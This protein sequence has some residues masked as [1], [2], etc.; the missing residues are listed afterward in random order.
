MGRA[1]RQKKDYGNAIDEYSAAVNCLSAQDPAKGIL[2]KEM[3]EMYMEAGDI[4]SSISEF[5]KAIQTGQY[6]QYTHLSLG[7]L[8]CRKKRYDLAD[9]EFDKAVD[10][11]PSSHVFFQ[12]IRIHKKYRRIHKCIAAS[13]NYVDKK[14]E[15]DAAENKAILDAIKSHA[16]AGSAGKELS[17]KIL[18]MPL[19]ER[20]AKDKHSYI[21]LP[22][23]GIGQLVAYLRGNDIKI[24]Q[25]DLYV[26][27]GH[28]NMFGKDED[29]IDMEIF[30]DEK[31][32]VE[33]SNG[34]EDEY[35]ENIMRKLEAKTNLKYDVMLLSL[36]CGCPN[37]SGVM[38]VLA[39]AKYIKKKYNAAILVGGH[40]EQ[41]DVLMSH[42]LRNID[43][44]G[45]G[46]G[47]KMLFVALTALK[48]GVN[49]NEVPDKWLVVKGKEMINGNVPYG[50]KADY[51]GLPFH[52]YEYAN[53]KR[54]TPDDKEFECILDG[55]NNSRLKVAEFEL[56]DGCFY[57][58]I[59]CCLSNVKEVFILSPKEA[60]DQLCELKEKY[61]ISN[62]MFM[63]SMINLSKKYVND[64]CDEI[65]SRKLDILWSDCARA[66]NLDRDTLNKMSRAGCV[67][68][69]YGMESASPRLLR[70]MNKGL[71]MGRIEDV[72]RWTH[73]AGILVG[74]ELICGFPGETKEDLDMTIDFVKRNKEHLD[75]CYCNVLYVR[76]TMRF[77]SEA[78]KYGV[79]NF[80]N[81]RYY[82]ELNCSVKLG[83]D[84]IGGLCWEDK[85]KEMQEHIKYMVDK[86][87][88]ERD[89]YRFE[90]EVE[91]FMF[92][93]FSKINDRN[94]ARY[95]F[96]KA[97]KY[98]V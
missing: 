27:V 92:Y 25:D 70:Y 10:I 28:D 12:L 11:D 66:D 55:F 83:Y 68:L 89:F 33:Y 29:R 96:R 8:F 21:L 59:F 56:M 22:P 64:F 54:T 36:D 87:Q 46:K 65:I 34:K 61:G 24:D 79:H 31:R 86:A 5:S 18:R 58:C 84:E 81:V 50:T 77:F 26:K 45:F 42:D 32:V 78:N 75:M 82:D 38:F 53:D 20:A 91:H 37:D 93:L 95:L 57:E 73:E 40:Y 63:N 43:Y 94:R 4:D 3:G 17:V 76:N 60:V 90:Y 19:V 97:K 98:L 14:R 39:L 13:I 41:L 80:R 30:L 7:E 23:F 16:N 44:V 67:R 72:L 49:L 71:R 52:L 51:D 2:H 62:F 35:I 88:K 48:Y 15:E 74:I 9:I 1:Y 47:E 85:F 6:D 69:I